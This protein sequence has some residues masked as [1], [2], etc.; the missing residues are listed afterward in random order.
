MQLLLDGRTGPYAPIF[1]QYQTK[2]KYFVSAALKR[3]KEHKCNSHQVH[4]LRN[5]SHG[6]PHF[7]SNTCTKSNPEKCGC[8]YWVLLDTVVVVITPIHWW[9]SCDIR[10]P[11]L[12]QLLGILS[13]SYWQ[14]CPSSAENLQY[15]KRIH[16]WTIIPQEL[17]SSD[18]LQMLKSINCCSK[19]IV[20]HVFTL[21]VPQIL[22]V[23]QN[24]DLLLHTS[25]EI[26]TPILLHIITR[27]FRAILWM[28]GIYMDVLFAY[29]S[30][31]HD[32]GDLGEYSNQCWGKSSWSCGE[33]PWPYVR[34]LQRVS[35][36]NVQQHF[37]STNFWQTLGR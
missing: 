23:Y 34:S 33:E 11:G 1:E 29:L 30:R 36:K 3:T 35:G 22:H 26:V 8:T 24:H 5:F 17:I 7:S 19:V 12:I 21:F 10:I 31:K 9:R 4:F 16:L 2:A 20:D 15:F 28:T 18:S 37:R 14:S 25:L 13:P 27:F 32:G 6:E